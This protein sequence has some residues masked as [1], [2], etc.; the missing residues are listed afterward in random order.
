MAYS[1]YGMKAADRF[2]R[3]VSGHIGNR[4]I[5]GL[6]AKLLKD[7]TNRTTARLIEEIGGDPKDLLVNGKINNADRLKMIQT[8]ANYT[9]GVTDLRGVP[10]WATSENPWARLSNKYRTFALANSAEIARLAH[11]APTWGEYV[12]RLSTLAIGGAAIG[13]GVNETRQAIYNAFAEHPPE[14]NDRSAWQYW[15]EN[16]LLGLGSVQAMVIL[17]AT[18][19]PRHLVSGLAGGPAAAKAGGLIEDLVDTVNHGVGWH[20]V[21]EATKSV[22][23]VGPL[24]RGPVKAKV[25]EETEQRQGQQKLIDSILGD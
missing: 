11:N 7:P 14:T 24:Y 20:S 25:A 5:Q 3:L 4:F 22:P 12:R 10:L 6:E 21:R 16:M 18:R 8:F 13:A 19:D 17:E 9:A 1:G 2:S 23:F 15:G